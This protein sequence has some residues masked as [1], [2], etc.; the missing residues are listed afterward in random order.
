[1]D[2]STR[3]VGAWLGPVVA[4]VLLAGLLAVGAGMATV[5]SDE[6]YGFAVQHPHVST[7]TEEIDVDGETFLV[8]SVALLE[9]DGE[10]HVDVDVP[11]DEAWAMELRD[12]DETVADFWTGVGGGE[13]V[14]EL[15]ED[16]D[17]FVLAL[18][19]D[20]NFHELQPVVIE[21]YD[22]D[23]THADT[24]SQDEPLEVTVDVTHGER[25]TEPDAIEVVA[26]DSDDHVIDVTATAI[27]DDGTYE[28]DLWFDDEPTGT[29]EVYALATDGTTD[30]PAVWAVEGGAAVTVEE[31]ED[32]DEED[33]GDDDGDGDEGDD[34]AIPPPPGDADGDDDHHEDDGDDANGDDVD[35]DGVG[36]EDV[37]EDADDD[38]AEDVDED[39]A[40]GAGEEGDGDA[41]DDSV[42]DGAT[43]T[44]DEADDAVQEPT[45]DDEPATDDETPTPAVLAVFAV[46]VLAALAAGRASRARGD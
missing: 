43:D 15:D 21:G 30:R 44:A 32:D 41:V 27:D 13:H 8:S 34:G 24:V 1:M 39:E 18:D 38:T 45:I 37:D 20:G 5:T 25:E 14:L 35:G 16:P 11:D 17:A 23:V 40:E 6:H 22:L 29:Y 28:A 33:D 9:P 26:F 12:R 2:P 10:L 19:V 42:A 31:A 4:V 36:D 7:P 46:L 3:R